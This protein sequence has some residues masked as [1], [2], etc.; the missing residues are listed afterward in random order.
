MTEDDTFNALRRSSYSEVSH[1]IHK[2]KK[3]S[4]EILKKHNW[5]LSEYTSHI[6]K[7]N[8]KK[9]EL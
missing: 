7:M 2:A 9:N 1:E 3:L 8:V 5:T 4:S 6:L